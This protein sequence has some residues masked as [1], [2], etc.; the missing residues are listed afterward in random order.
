MICLYIYI[1]DIYSTII[2]GLYWHFL[3]II[4]ISI[5]ASCSMAHLI[6]LF[7]PNGQIAFLTLVF[8][9]VYDC[10]LLLSNFFVNV[11]RLNI[12]YQ[13]VSYF[14]ISRWA[15]E[16]V[17]LLIYGFERCEKSIQI[18]PVLKWLQIED[19]DYLSCIVLLLLNC[20]I[21]R[22]IVFCLLLL[23][24]NSFAF[25]KTKLIQ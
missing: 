6:V 3:L 21:F 18:H 4:I 14:S 13:I 16:A 11:H 24:T 15:F 25:F 2:P 1:C 19:D 17:L 5:Y 7:T 9:I 20:L 8:M 10:F 23:R 22:V 12:F